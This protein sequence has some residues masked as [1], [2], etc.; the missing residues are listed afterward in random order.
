M[1]ER[2]GYIPGVPCWVDTS[3]PDPDAAAAFYGSLFGWEVEDAMPAGSEVK[4][5]VARL[6]GGDVAA[7]SSKM[8]DAPPVTWLTYVWVSS[9][10]ETAAKVAQAGGAVVME[11]FD[12][13][14]AGRMAVAA[15]REG[16][17]FAVWEAR[18][19]RGAQIVNEPGALNFTVLNT[20]DPAEA[21]AFYGSVFGWRTFDLPAG[22][23]WTLP[24]YGDHLEELT[25]GLRARTAEFGVPG[26]EDVVA[27]FTTIPAEDREASACWNVTFGADD[28]DATAAQATSLGGEV[29][30]PP[31]DAPFV[32]MTV[33][34]DPQGATFTASQ[35][36]PGN[37]G[38][39]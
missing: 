10:D 27:A 22:Q 30:V 24:G 11:P 23:A 13:F 5:L 26:F 35:F 6:R 8:D 21:R 38:S 32:R 7:I 28:A 19:H 20:R 37:A 9:A 17:V 34:R 39:A 4:Y 31:F 15:D 14:G 2:D 36:V 12:V 25:P 33:L 1:A 16:A 29:V 18:E 3:Q